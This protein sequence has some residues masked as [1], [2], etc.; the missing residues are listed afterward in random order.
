M[1]Q[2]EKFVFSMTKNGKIVKRSIV[3]LVEDKGSKP[4]TIIIIG[5]GVAVVILIILGGN[6]IIIH[7]DRNQVELF[8]VVLCCVCKNRCS[9][10]V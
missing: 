5:V 8:S 7:F 4:F 6:I 3:T 2:I 9:N 10:Q 1:N